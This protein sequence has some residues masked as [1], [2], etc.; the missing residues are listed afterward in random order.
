MQTKG[1]TFSATFR[2]PAAP[3]TV[4][5]HLRE[6]ELLRR[7]FGWHGPEFESEIVGLS[8]GFSTVEDDGRSVV[9]GDHRMALAEIGSETE[10]HL[11]RITEAEAHGMEIDEGWVTF[12]EQLRFVVAEQPEGQRHTFM[13]GGAPTTEPQWPHEEWARSAHQRTVIVRGSGD[14]QLAIVGSADG[15]P[16]PHVVV[17]SY[18]RTDSE[19]AELHAE[20][21]AWVAGTR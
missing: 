4:W 17:N 10:L 8:G 12:L 20:I 2:M 3:D 1:T 13:T 7:W 6:P 21:A 14:V 18:G 15:G 16:S 11:S 5:R 9:I 19:A